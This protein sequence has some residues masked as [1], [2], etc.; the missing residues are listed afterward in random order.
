MLS[1]LALSSILDIVPEVDPV[2]MD[3]ESGDTYYR[4][5]I[6]TG[7]EGTIFVILDLAP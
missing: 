4:G 2:I 3:L 5:Q 6:E 7:I 1:H